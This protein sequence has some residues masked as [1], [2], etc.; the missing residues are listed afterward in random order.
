LHRIGRAVYQQGK[1]L[2]F[3]GGEDVVEK[4][5]LEGELGIDVTMAR[6][7]QMHRF[8]QLVRWSIFDELTGRT[9]L[10]AET[11]M[12]GSACLLNSRLLAFRDSEWTSSINGSP[13]DLSPCRVRS[14]MITSGLCCRKA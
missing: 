5:Q 14:T 6:P 12:P 11:K 2:S 9:G 10:T 3:L 8:C 4:R 1:Y 7:K 13:P